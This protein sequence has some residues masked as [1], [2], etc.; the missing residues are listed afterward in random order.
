MGALL[1]ITIVAVAVVLV[2][3]YIVRQA[4]RVRRLQ[5]QINYSRVRPWTDDEEDE[6][7]R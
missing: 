3:A 1:A 5:E 4:R 6:E 7:Q 2:V